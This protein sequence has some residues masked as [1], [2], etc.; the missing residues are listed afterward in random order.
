[1]MQCPKCQTILSIENKAVFTTCPKCNLLLFI[2]KKG[3]RPAE[4]NDIREKYWQVNSLVRWAC[5]TILRHQWSDEG[6]LLSDDD[7]CV[8]MKVCKRCFCRFEKRERHVFI[9]D[10]ISDNSCEKRRVCTKCGHVVI[11][12][13][14]EHSF[15][16][17]YFIEGTCDRERRCS[18]CGLVEKLGTDHMFCDPDWIVSETDKCVSTRT[19]RRCG[20]VEAA[21][22]HSGEWVVIGMKYITPNDEEIIYQEKRI[23]EVCGFEEY[24]ESFYHSAY[25]H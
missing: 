22:T 1:M 16:P 3:L 23:C 9:E 25:H 8:K 20:Q 11:S 17:S 14:P 7:Q 18:H 12:E 2:D 6:Y 10:Y 24:Q 21:V 15:L 5:E 19:C 13:S 4:D